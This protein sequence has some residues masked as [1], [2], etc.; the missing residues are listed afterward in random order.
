MECVIYVLYM[1]LHLEIGVCCPNVA[2]TLFRRTAG[3]TLAALAYCQFK[4]VCTRVRVCLCLKNRIFLC[5]VCVRARAPS[6]AFS[7][8]DRHRRPRRA[9]LLAA[10]AAR[11]VTGAQP[12][13]LGVANSGP[14][15]GDPAR[16]RAPPQS[17]AAP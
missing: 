14:V 4:F 5:G 8:P 11:T 16:S 13:G 9:R 3:R 6:Y 7:S 12:G 2:V 10:A 15:L 1:C 17:I